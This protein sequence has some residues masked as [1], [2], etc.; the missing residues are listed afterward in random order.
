MVDDFVLGSEYAVRQ[1]VIA[2]ELP[3][4]L[5]WVEL[6]AFRRDSNDRD[7]GGHVEPRRQM[8]TGLIHEQYGMGAG[9]DVERNLGEVQVHGVGV[10]ERQQQAC[11]LAF[12]RT[13]RTE[14]IGGFGTLV[15]RCRRPGP[16]LRPSPGDLVLLPD[17]SL[18]LEPDFYWR[19]AREGGSDLVQLGGKTPFLK[20]SLA[21]GS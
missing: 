18:V 15:V 13:D 5:L 4:L 8:P 1:P 16:P 19:A 9:C 20:A 14:D 7:V 10:T 2:H 3:H 21:S 17:P 11:R 6:R 12:V